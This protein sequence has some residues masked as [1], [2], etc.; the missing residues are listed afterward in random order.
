MSNKVIKLPDVMKATALS[1]SSIYAYIKKGMFPAQVQVGL[2]AVGW[3]ESEIT[4]FISQRTE[5]RETKQR[6]QENAQ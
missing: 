4:T 5:L 2:R 6:G 3:L 1:R